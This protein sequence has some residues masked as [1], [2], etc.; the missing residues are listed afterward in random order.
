MRWLR[1]G[2]IAGFIVRRV[3][4]GVL[5]LFLVSVDRLRLDAG[6]R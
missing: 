3:L 6:P 1:G 5:V 4:L 2:G